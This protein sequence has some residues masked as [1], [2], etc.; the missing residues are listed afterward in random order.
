MLSVGTRDQAVLNRSGDDLRIDWGY[1][2]IAIP[3]SEEAKSTITADPGRAFAK[4]GTLPVADMMD[5]PV[6]LDRFAPEMAIALPLGSVGNAPVSKHVLVSY[7]DGYAV[8][9][10]GSIDI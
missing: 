3:N 9:V 7:T 1:F 4:D 8:Q 2:H 5:G 6:P 10:L